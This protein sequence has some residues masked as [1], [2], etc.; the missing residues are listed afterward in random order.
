[1]YLAVK[2]FRPSPVLDDVV[3]DEVGMEREL[4]AA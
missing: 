2:G 4:A 3:A 1:V